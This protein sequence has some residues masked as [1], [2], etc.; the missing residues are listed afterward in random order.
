MPAARPPAQKSAQ[1]ITRDFL[2]RFLATCRGSRRDCRNRALLMLGWTSW[3]R[4]RSEITGLRREDVN[5]KESDEESLVGIS[6][7]ETKTTQTGR[8]R[9]WC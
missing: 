5:L 4:R 8:R 3:G 2:E 6:L 9:G 7:L 1:P